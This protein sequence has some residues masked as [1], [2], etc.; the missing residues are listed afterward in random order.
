MLKK[1][2]KTL[3]L[4]TFMTLI[5]MIVGII[6]W[7]KLPAEIATHFDFQ[8]NADG[9]SGK[10]MAVFGLPG[11]C[12]IIH[13]MCAYFTVHD[14]KFEN[15]SKKI[16]SI[17]LWICPIISILCSGMVYIYALGGE[18]YISKITPLLCGI[19]FVIIGNYL[20][21]TRRNYTVGIKIPWTLA[22]DENW[23]KT[24]RMAG[25]LWVV[26]GLLMIIGVFLPMNFFN[27]AFL[28]ITLVMVIVPMVYSFTIYKKG[29]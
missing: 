24:H 26:C 15:I 12:F 2:K 28:P 14:P 11:I 10:G 27:Y 25:K 5:P 13:V 18:N 21:K 23:N 22:D 8:G 17:V 7:N 4:T 19:L 3:I 1:Y 9:W 6:L 29:N 16:F 20:P